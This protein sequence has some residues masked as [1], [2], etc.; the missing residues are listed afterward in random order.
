MD[1][2][3]VFKKRKSIRSFDEK[4]KISEEQLTKIL[5]AGK[6]APSAGRIYPVDF[7]VVSEKKD[8]E[9]IAKVANN[10]NFIAEAPLII[11]V[12]ANVE[13]SASYYGERGRS[14]YAI[15]DAAAATENMILAAVALGLST[16]WVGAFDEEKVGE[17]LGLNGGERPLTILPIGQEK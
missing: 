9:K 3:E 14:L 8:K 7:F 15:Q 6:Q 1:I 13:K 16:C 10:Q 5:A 4:I 12:V 2:W 17:V 11:V